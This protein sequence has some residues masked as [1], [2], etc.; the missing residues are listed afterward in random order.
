MRALL[1][2]ENQLRSDLSEQTR[3]ADEYFQVAEELARENV[4][5]KLANA[6]LKE[7]QKSRPGKHY[8]G[9]GPLGD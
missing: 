7:M 5:L 8:M 6:W 2:I 4:A 9:V 1:V 3:W